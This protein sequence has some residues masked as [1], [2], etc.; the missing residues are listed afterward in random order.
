[1]GGT[2]KGWYTHPHT[3]PALGSVNCA[4]NTQK[5]LDRAYSPIHRAK[6][7]RLHGFDWYYSIGVVRGREWEER[8]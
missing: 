8:P 3:V 4:V 1:M 2:A 5:T 6:G 7:S